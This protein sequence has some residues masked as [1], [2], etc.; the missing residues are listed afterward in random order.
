MAFEEKEHKK[1]Q[2]QNDWAKDLKGEPIHINNAKSGANG[3][4]CLGCDKEM[5]AVKFKNPK[6]Q[7]YYRHHAQNIDKENT[8][9]VVAS[10]KYRVRLAAFILNRIKFINAPP[11]YK[12][13]P[14]NEDGLPMFLKG[15]ETINAHSVVSELTFYEDEQGNIL[16]GKNPTIE[17]RYLLV[18][19]DV[20]FFDAKN[21]PI[22]FIEFVI[23]HKL[24]TEKKVKLNRLGINTVQ[25][26][27]PKVPEEEIEKALKSSRKYKWIYN[28]L[29]A[30]TTYISVS[31]GNS[32]GI[33][34][35]DEIQ[36]KLFEESFKCR[37][38]QINQLVR[39]INKCLRSE[40]YR[41]TERLFESELSRLSN[42]RKAAQQRLGELE[43][44]HRENALDRNRE[45]HSKI[46]NEY[47][48]LEERYNNKN[49]EL[50]QATEEYY[51]DQRVRES[52][53]YHI[54]QE[55]SA[56]KRIEQE[57]DEFGARAQL[58]E[59][60]MGEEI[61]EQF[62]TDTEQIETRIED[63]RTDR[64]KLEEKVQ[65]SINEDIK[66]AERKHQ[67]SKRD[68][69]GKINLEENEITR[70]EGEQNS[71]ES[72]TL[73]ELRKGLDENSPELST[74]IKTLLEVRRVASDFE[75]AK[76]EEEF[77]KRVEKF[78]NKK[79]WSRG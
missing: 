11:V 30:N 5:Q 68:F 61:W 50:Q 15:R 37:T 3:Y 21:E 44:Q 47:S 41:R 10:R 32:E 73:N 20:T 71:L 4:Y 54:E 67:E 46:K 16:H 48:N 77:Y 62:R 14:I 59:N 24:T 1:N 60:R 43:K 42:N 39:N 29:E 6:Y 35:I 26:I 65:S 58:A 49:Q 40:S 17:D 9:C 56:I 36:R 19:P 27:I 18:R 78:F 12:Y 52:I 66:S 53:E 13:P 64:A 33:S 23:T 51:S 55:E 38:A 8:K 25:I 7:S 74:R 72:T 69:E 22:L 2:Y 45:T 34:P 57:T 75:V 31:E 79:T 70:I 28:E 63:V 76:C